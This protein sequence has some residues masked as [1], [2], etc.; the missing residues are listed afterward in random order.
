MSVNWDWASQAACK[1][2]PELFHPSK[3]T[4]RSEVVAALAYCR[5][6]PVVTECASYALKN[7]EP[8][9]IWGGMTETERKEL[10]LRRGIRGEPEPK[11][12]PHGTEYGQKLHY[13]RGEKPCADCQAATRRAR[14]DRVARKLKP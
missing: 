2:A 7:C 6:C 13:L 11:P 10:L 3:Y 5:A 8:Y 4:P 12:I 9:G 1:A 14:A